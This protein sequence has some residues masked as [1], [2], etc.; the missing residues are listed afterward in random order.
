MFLA[1][2]LA[3]SACHAHMVSAPGGHSQYGPVNGASRGGVIKYRNTGISPV[4]RHRRENAYRQMYNA[5]GGRYR[6]DTEGPRS[7]GGRVYSDALGGVT[8]QSAEYWYIQFSCVPP[9]LPVA[10]DGQAPMLGRQDPPALTTPSES[11]APPPPTGAPLSGSNP[12]ESVRPNRGST[13]ALLLFGGD[14]HRTFL[15]CLNCSEFDPKSVHNEFGTYG[16]EFNSDSIFNEFGEFGSAFSS[17]SACN[18]FASDP[19][20]IVDRDGSF[21]GRLTLNEFREQVR[22]P[23]IVAWLAGVCHH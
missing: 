21:H 14:G 11:S 9:Q 18:E 15:G 22:D 8:V 10:E 23:E 16:N 6:I 2:P 20:V 19:P 3:T 12:N 7:E 17:H 4:I 1:L 5:C 13:S